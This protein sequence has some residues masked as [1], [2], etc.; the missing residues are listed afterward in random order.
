MT[1]SQ[2]VYVLLSMDCEP[3]KIDVTPYALTLSGSGP[4]NYAESE[5]S[6]RGYVAIANDY[7]FPVTLFVHPEVAAAHPD[8]LLELQ[9]GGA[10]LGLHLHP[11]KLRGRDYKFDLGAYS[12]D[13]QRQIVSEAMEAWERALGQ[14]PRYF[15]GGVF[16]ANDSTFQVLHELGFN[17][18][19]LSCPGRVLPEAYAIWAGAEPYPHQAHLNFRQTR[20]RSDFIEVPISVAFHRPMEQGDR[21]E[22]GYEWP[23]I[24]SGNYNHPEVIRD[25]LQRFKADSARHGTIVTDTH[26]DMNYADPDHHASKKLRAILDSIDSLCVDMAMQPAGVTIETVRDMILSIED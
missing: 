25:I 15:R 5:R 8:L 11:Y 7:G 1:T 19:S 6:I 26:N 9:G 3:A 14:K 21:G 10:C 16:S 17:G 20:G 2:N 23:Y 18:G 4:A 12:A 22:Q 24:P 13:E